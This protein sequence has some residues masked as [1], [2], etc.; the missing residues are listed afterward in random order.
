MKTK[1][2][3]FEQSKLDLVYVV[4]NYQEK[5]DKESLAFTYYDALIKDIKNCTSDSQLEI[6]QKIVKGLEW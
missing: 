3:R 1:S 5:C 2:N 6:L 4:Y